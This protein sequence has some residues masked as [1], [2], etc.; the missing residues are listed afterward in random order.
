MKLQRKHARRVLEVVD[1][2]L[3]SG[4]G[5]AEPGRMCVEAAICYALKLPHGDQPECVADCIR[6]YK[7]RINVICSYQGYE[8]GASY[9]DSICMDGRLYDADDCDDNGNLYEPTEDI[10]CPMCREKD[11]VDYIGLIGLDAVTA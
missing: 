11:A 7:I 8:F 10:P 9:P 4:L 5:I 2:G 3:V 6:R 1:A